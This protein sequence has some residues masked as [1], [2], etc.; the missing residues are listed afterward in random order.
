MSDR[1][2]FVNEDGNVNPNGWGRILDLAR[3]SNCELRIS[4]NGRITV[5]SVESGAQMHSL[6]GDTIAGSKVYKVITYDKYDKETLHYIGTDE[7][8]ALA[9]FGNTMPYWGVK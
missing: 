8:V 7:G 9:T 4:P 6:E 3:K 1:R 2:Y 5:S